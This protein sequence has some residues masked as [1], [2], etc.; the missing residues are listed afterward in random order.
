MATFKFGFN[1]GYALIFFYG[2]S[3]FLVTFTLTRH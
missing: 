1:A 3:G 2:I